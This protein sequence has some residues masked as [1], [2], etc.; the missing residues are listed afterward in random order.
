M[1]R[2][3]KCTVGSRV[4]GVK[5]PTRRPAPVALLMQVWEGAQAMP[6]PQFWAFGAMVGRAKAPHNSARVQATMVRDFICNTLYNSV[7]RCYST[8]HM[9][10]Q[11]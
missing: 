11:T 10:R 6:L 4:Q 9:T 7:L 1:T 8:F 2:A 5:I 3:F